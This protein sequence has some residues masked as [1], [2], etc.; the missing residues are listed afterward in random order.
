M[1]VLCEGQGVNPG[2]QGLLEPLSLLGH[3]TALFFFLLLCLVSSSHIRGG[4]LH[5][6]LLP[7]MFQDSLPGLR[8]INGKTKEEW[9]GQRKAVHGCIALRAALGLLLEVVLSTIG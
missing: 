9:F 3:S 6:T 7:I 2:Y 8:H 5:C 4:C 1:P